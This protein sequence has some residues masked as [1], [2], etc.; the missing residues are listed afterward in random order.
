MIPKTKIRTRPN[1]SSPQEPWP[2]WASVAPV[3]VRAASA[4]PELDTP[5]VGRSRIG[6]NLMSGAR[7]GTKH[8]QSRIDATE[9]LGG[10]SR[11]WRCRARHPRE[12]GRAS[13]PDH[14]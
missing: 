8:A 9:S 6:P 14:D 4:G 13:E 1:P 12:R 2:F 5:L 3:Q 10:R 11:A 7:E